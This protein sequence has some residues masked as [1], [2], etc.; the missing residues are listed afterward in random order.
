LDS[1]HQNFTGKGC[2]TSGRYWCEIEVCEVYL[3][4]PMQHTFIFAPY[5][6]DKVYIQN[7]GRSIR[8]LIGIGQTNRNP[9][10]KRG[11][12]CLVWSRYTFDLYYPWQHTGI[13]LV[14][15]AKINILESEGKCSPSFGKSTKHASQFEL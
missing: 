13:L 4:F 11:N 10:Q 7:A 3:L 9:N 5:I 2:A 12:Q 14:V 6:E 15:D 8:I 1:Y